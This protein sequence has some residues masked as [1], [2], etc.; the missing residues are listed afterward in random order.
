VNNITQRRYPITDV[1]A[2]IAIGYVLFGDRVDFHMFKVFDD[3][4]H[5]ISAVLGSAGH[6][7]T[8]W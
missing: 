6:S 1:E 8:G 2:G 3:K 4:V 7:S 5:L